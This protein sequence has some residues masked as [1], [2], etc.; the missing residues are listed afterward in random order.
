MQRRC[1]G[2]LDNIPRQ[3]LR[4]CGSWTL[5][6]STRDATACT[7]SKRALQ[8]VPNRPIHSYNKVPFIRADLAM[9][10]QIHESKAPRVLLPPHT[11]GKQTQWDVAKQRSCPAAIL[12]LSVPTR[13]SLGWQKNSHIAQFRRAT[14]RNARSAS[15]D[16]GVRH[17]K[18]PLN[19]PA[20]PPTKQRGNKTCAQAE[21]KTKTVNG[22]VLITP[23]TVLPVQFFDSGYDSRQCGIIEGCG[24][25]RQTSRC[26]PAI[27]RA[28]RQ[29][30]S[31][32]APPPPS[33]PRPCWTPS[34]DRSPAG[35]C[36]S[37]RPSKQPAQTGRMGGVLQCTAVPCSMIG[38]A[39]RWC[40]PN[41]AKSAVF[42]RAEP[43][44]CRDERTTKKVYTVY[45]ND[46]PALK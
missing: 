13:S 9:I 41:R 8:H 19:P 6:L 25:S 46:D 20:P 44:R 7:A 4:Y 14:Y 40:A 1:R 36:P 24:A 42:L 27:S 10:K 37:R 29:E 21:T 28:T 16:C 39:A 33:R 32:R 45:S 3:T 17:Q 15:S 2:V 43:I 38:Q 26:Q 12:I 22:L 34:S 30:A 35:R 23:S 18:Y 5:Q 11:P 31:A